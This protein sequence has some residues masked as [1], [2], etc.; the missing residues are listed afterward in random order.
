MTH[1]HIQIVLAAGMCNLTEQIRHKQG[2]EITCKHTPEKVQN[3][4]TQLIH[5]EEDIITITAHDN[6]TV[7]LASH[8]FQSLNMQH[9]VKQKA[10]CT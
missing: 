2:T 4:T 3:I 10:Y 8:Q 9:S 1:S 7:K 5:F 6:I